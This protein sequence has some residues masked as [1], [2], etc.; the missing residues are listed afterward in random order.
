MLKE[1]TDYIKKIIKYEKEKGLVGLINTAYSSL[2]ERSLKPSI[3]RFGNKNLILYISPRIG[4][5]TLEPDK[6]HSISLYFLTQIEGIADNLRDDI[7]K[8]VSDVE[9]R[10]INLIRWCNK[11][12]MQLLNVFHFND[13]EL[14]T[15]SGYKNYLQFYNKF[16]ETIGVEDFA[17]KGKAIKKIGIHHFNIKSGAYKKLL[18]SQSSVLSAYNLLLENKKPFRLTLNGG[19]QSGGSHNDDK[20]YDFMK[21]DRGLT[22]RN[23]E[24]NVYLMSLYKPLEK[25]E[26]V[27]LN[28][29]LD[30]FPQQIMFNK[31]GYDTNLYRQ[32]REK[33]KILE[34]VKKELGENKIKYEQIP[35]ILGKK[36]YKIYKKVRTNLKEAK[37]FAKS[38][39]EFD[40]KFEIRGQK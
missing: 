24:S 4:E 32:K 6:I 35:K 5:N 7:F 16:L 12:S 36:Y 30:S 3:L 38:E 15:E 22:L 8:Y 9:N 14:L 13:I 1:K 37:S 28:K 23:H 20:I 26:I 39:A 11:E 19:T 2:A 34:K 33:E 17:W 18:L 21:S 29:I 10:S 27:Q 31:I 25:K 40:Y